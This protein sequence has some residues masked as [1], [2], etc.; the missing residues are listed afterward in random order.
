MI[1]RLNIFLLVLYILLIHALLAPTHI[2]NHRRRHHQQLAPLR[3]QQ[4]SI[5]GHQHYYGYLIITSS[6]SEW[7]GIYRI[8]SFDHNKFVNCRFLIKVETQVPTINE[9]VR[10][11]GIDYTYFSLASQRV[12][13]SG[14]LALKC[15]SLPSD[16]NDTNVYSSRQ[17]SLNVRYYWRT[18][19]DNDDHHRSNV[20][21]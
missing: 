20:D 8:E 12:R 5:R 17:I 3:V 10:F 2:M 1:H 6:P 4:S 13:F 21:E 11:Y 18:K 14:L 15:R 7:T 16:L 9:Q 19:L